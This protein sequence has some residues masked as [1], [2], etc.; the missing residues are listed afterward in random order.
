MPRLI[1]FWSMAPVNGILLNSHLLL[2]LSHG[3]GA[4]VEGRMFRMLR[5]G[6]LFFSRFAHFQCL[7]LIFGLSRSDQ[8]KL[9]L[10]LFFTWCVL[11]LDNLSNSVLFNRMYVG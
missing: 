10:I 6:S 4:N 9:S 11:Q 7:F 1:E 3:L 2:G 8:L 5:L